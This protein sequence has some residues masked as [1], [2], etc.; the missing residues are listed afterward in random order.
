MSEYKATYNQIK[1]F[2]KKWI[3]NVEDVDNLDREVVVLHF[4]NDFKD[5]Y[6]PLLLEIACNELG[7]KMY[8]QK[9]DIQPK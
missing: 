5:Q 9:Y 7:I 4:Q 2:L 1:A 8:H 3:E 6:D